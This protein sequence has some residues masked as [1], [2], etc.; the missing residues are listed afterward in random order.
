MKQKIL[1]MSKEMEEEVNE[2]RQQ[3]IKERGSHIS[4]TG[5]VL[6]LINKDLKNIKGE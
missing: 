4:F 3:L 2:R 6:E 1:Y 5:Y